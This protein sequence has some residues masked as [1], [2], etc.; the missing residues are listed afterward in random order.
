[1]EG[2]GEVSGGG[3]VAWRGMGWHVRGCGGEGGGG[4]AGG[5]G[6]G[7]GGGGGEGGRQF[8]PSV[9]L[10]YVII[11]FDRASGQCDFWHP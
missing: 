2:G 5:G 7:G 8:L 10:S 9:K 4:G 11:P 1:M 6:W 3:G